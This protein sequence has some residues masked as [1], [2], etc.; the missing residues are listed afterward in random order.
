MLLLEQQR[1]HNLPWFFQRGLTVGLARMPFSRPPLNRVTTTR[2]HLTLCKGRYIGG[3]DQTPPEE[4]AEHGGR[5]KG[6]VKL[7]QM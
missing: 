2:K 1:L 7:F 6:N 3:R 4:T 5:D